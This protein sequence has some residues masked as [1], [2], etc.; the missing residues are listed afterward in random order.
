MS[1]EEREVMPGKQM[2]CCINPECDRVTLRKTA[3]GLVCP[4]GHFFPY[5]TGTEVPIFKCKELGTNEYSLEDSAKIHD[6]ALRWVCKTF[7]TKESTL[8]TRLVSRLGLKEGQRV[9]VT[10]AGAGNDLL[11]I[12]EELGHNGEIY[13]QDIAKQ[14]LMAGVD[15]H[16]KKLE[17]KGGT[18]NF[19]I[20][21]AANLPFK[22]GF[23]D[24]AYHF[25]GINLFP[26]IQKGIEEMNRVV[27]NGGKI[28][29]S[30]EGLAPWLMDTE[31]GKML[32]KNNP[33]YAS[34]IPLHLLP[35][36]A[37]DV[38]LSWELCNCF[39]VLEFTVSDEPLRINIDVPHVGKRGG[40]IRTRYYGELEGIAP[41]IRDRIYEAAEKAG[42]SRVDYMESLLLA[43]LKG[44]E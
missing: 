13:A 28:V 41:E 40:S 42:K 22:E 34:E 20:S 7:D 38:R 21:D 39:Y 19:S 32:I 18:I 26:D 25:G 15:R 11:Y 1:K 5:A 10:G 36:N 23:F 31:F 37:R 27:K 43:G 29:I 3:D 24:A 4:N 33:L 14:M 2:Y 30:D 44:E 9:L 8:R 12:A 17:K 16:Q 35:G 6:N